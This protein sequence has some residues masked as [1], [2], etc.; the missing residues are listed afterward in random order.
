MTDFKIDYNEVARRLVSAIIDGYAIAARELSE[1]HC[2]MVENVKLIHEQGKNDLDTLNTAMA[3]R[4]FGH[5]V[6]EYFAEENFASTTS[7]A[8]IA[9]KAAQIAFN[10]SKLPGVK[11]FFYTDFWRN[12]GFHM[13]IRQFKSDM[14]KTI[15]DLKECTTEQGQHDTLVN[16]GQDTFDH[17]FLMG[18]EA[19]F[20][21]D[22]DSANFLDKM[23][24]LSPQGP[25]LV[26]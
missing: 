14:A 23:F 17:L 11:R 24:D 13:A 8:K 5:I 19:D 25:G 9:Q 12:I 10:C 6:K 26:N 3:L 4:T 7:T 2:A 16:L 21:I 15:Y 18:G 1:R 20:E 22:E